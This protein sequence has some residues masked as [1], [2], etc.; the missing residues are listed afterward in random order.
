MT[1]ARIACIVEGRGEAGLTGSS[2]A[3]EILLRRIVEVIDLDVRVQVPIALRIPR[4]SLI[5]RGGVEDAVERA[6]R[7]LGGH[8]AIVVLLDSDDDPREPL[9]ADLLARARLIRANLPIAVVAAKYEFE[10][11]FL[12]AAESLAGVEGLPPDL[13]A[14]SNPEA[15]RDAKGWL[16][17]RMAGGKYSATIHQ[18]TF[19]RHFDLQ[20]ARGALSFGHCWDE[21]ARLITELRQ[22]EKPDAGTE[23]R[24]EA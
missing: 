9:E 13:R 1:V 22:P 19:T 3:A 4:G 7:R 2:G 20:A 15:I 11:W 17:K 16:G 5:R 12:A 6:A 10:T 18:A 21:I 23:G 14:P 24:T 8:G